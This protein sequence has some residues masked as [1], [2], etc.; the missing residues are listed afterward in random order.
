MAKEITI[1]KLQKVKKKGVAKKRK[2]KRE[3]KKQ[4]R[5]QGR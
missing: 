2:N 3:N 1:K 4:Y 5:G